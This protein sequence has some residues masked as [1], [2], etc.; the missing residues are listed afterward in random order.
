MPAIVLAGAFILSAFMPHGIDAATTVVSR[1][2]NIQE[3]INAATPGDTLLIEDGTY[4]ECLV[5]DRPL[6]LRAVN[7]GKVTVTNRHPG[8]VRW[9]RDESRPGIWYCEGITWPVHRLLVNGIQAFDYRNKTNFDERTC[10]PFWSKTWQEGRQPYLVPPY[11]FAGD[12]EQGRLWLRLPD[13]R[14]PNTLVIDFNGRRLDGTTLVQKDLGTAW[15][16]QEIVRISASEPSGPITMWYGGTPEAPT[17]GRQIV[18]PKGC[19][20]I[21]SIQADDVT[22]EGLRIHMAPTVG[23]EVNDS[24][25]VVIRDCFFS[26]FQY[27]INTGYRCTHLTVTQCE[28]D[29]GQLVTVGGHRDVNLLMWDHSTYVNP[30]K[31]NG[32]GLTFTHNYVYE[33]YDL[34]HPRGRHK[35][36]PNIPDIPS[37]VAYNVWHWNVDNVF[38]F[39]GVEAR[40]QMRVHHNLVISRRDAVAFTTTENGAPLT[41]DHNLFWP[42]GGHIIKLTGTGRTNRGVRFVHNTL[43][44]GAHASTAPFEDSI[45][46]NNIMISPADRTDGWTPEPLGSFFPTRFNLIPNAARFMKGFQGLAGDPKFGRTPETFFIPEPGSPAIDAGRSNPEYHQTN[47]TDGRPDLGAVEA[48]STVADWRKEFGRCGPSWITADNAETLAPNRPKWPREI[49]RR[50]GGLE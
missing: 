10:G 22:I 21:I 24:R 31:F 34:F 46:E 48:G 29:G 7:P 50:W 36:Y 2:E 1:D 40:L 18:L 12:L 5:I 13:D 33:G 30:V 28:M 4:H 14:D 19:G 35:D 8:P 23:V 47:V 45:F 16:Q 41:V 32:T 15:N 27:A 11:S 44:T 39:D 25:R 49:D 9:E 42:G 20:V 26:G 38:E 43:F 3:A 6:T 37:E 17:D